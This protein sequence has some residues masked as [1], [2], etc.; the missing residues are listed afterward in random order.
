M[1]LNV[2]GGSINTNYLPTINE[3]SLYTKW[4]RS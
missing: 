2:L 4:L 3:E 1:N